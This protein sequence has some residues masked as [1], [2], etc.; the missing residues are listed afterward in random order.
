MTN[1]TTPNADQG[2]NPGHDLP[3]SK[4]TFIVPPASNNP[5]KT[6][7]PASANVAKLAG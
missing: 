7:K 4:S 3:R 1:N 6:V 2:A 5:T